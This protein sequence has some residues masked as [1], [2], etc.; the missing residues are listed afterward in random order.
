MRSFLFSLRSILVLL[1][2]LAAL[3]AIGLA[4]YNASRETVEARRRA[5]EQVLSLVH[6]AAS[7]HKTL[8]ASA[9]QLL[10]TLVELPE[11][12]PGQVEACNALLARLLPLHPVFANLGVTDAN[13]NV[14][15]SAVPTTTAVNVADRAWFIRA[16]Q[17]RAFASGD[18]QIGR[19]TGKAVI[20]FSHPILDADNQV[21][22]VAFAALDLSW[23][24]KLAQAATLPPEAVYTVVD[25]QGRILARQPGGEAWLG[26]VA[27]EQSVV[28][29]ALATSKEGMA[30]APGVDGVMRLY[31]Y[32]P[33]L[34]DGTPGAYVLVGLPVS[35]VYA[36][37]G[38]MLWINLG[39]LGG[40]AVLGLLAA[41][42]GGEVF[43][44]RPIHSLL[45]A[46]RRM[47]Q[48][49]LSARTAIPPG[50][51][52]LS[53]LARAFD[54]M[55]ESLESAQRNYRLLFENLPQG[56]AVHEMIWDEEGNAVDYRFLS[57][58]PAFERLT[59]LK[60][61]DILGKT[62]RQVL[63]EI[64]AAW[65]GTH[66]QVVR[67][68]QPIVYE[69]FASPLG[70]YYS[71]LAYKPAEGQFATIVSDITE[72]TRHE[73]EV[74]AQAQIAYALAESLELQFLLDRLLLAAIHAVPAAEKGF[75]LL[76]DERGELQLRS[77]KGYADRR[78]RDVRFPSELGYI[79]LAFHQRRGLIIA[80]A[81]AEPKVR[82]Q[83]EI[84]ELM[85][86]LSAMAVPL[87]VHE[88]TIGVIA[89]Q[90]STRKAA[91]DEHDLNVL[92]TMASTAALII[93]NAR[94]YEE[95]ANRLERIEALRKIDM[96]ITS[97]LDPRVSLSVLLDQVTGRLSVDA[98][99]VLLYNPYL[100]ELN[101]A[102]AR[103]FRTRTIERTRLRL[104]EGIA[105][106]VALERSLV[107]IQ[108]LRQEAEFVRKDLL[109]A[110]GFISYIAVPMI[111]KG[112]LLGVLEVFNRSP[113]N[114]S[115]EW[116]AF[117]EA[118]AAQAAIAIE[119]AQ[120]FNGLQRSN[121]ELMRAY[122]TTIEGWS[123]ALDL[124]DKET[125]GHTQRVTQMTLNLGGAMGMSDAELVHVRR[126]ALLHDIGKMGIP[127]VILLKPGPLTEEEWE[128]MRKHPVYAYEMLYP[129]E[130]LRPALDI[131]YCHHEK[132]D[133]TGYP[134]GLKGEQIP[135]AARIFA[136]VDVW[137]AL[138]S[139]RP[140]RPA[141]SRQAALEYIREQNGKHFDPEVVRVFM[142]IIASE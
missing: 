52:E 18:Y 131:P 86:V 51:D 138:T 139:D 113:L 102:A 28:S 42:L 47:A 140:Y 99:A 41:W 61:D 13:G 69:Q 141:W 66:G 2:L 85:R 101:Y 129:I 75:I 29:Q 125:E 16:V 120:L 87:I 27:S 63:P 65:V 34:V 81:Q 20:V 111:A 97:S 23:L 55:A 59:G 115:Q 117:L 98:A 92:S 48:G 40:A 124:R 74:E 95:T 88:R 8:I 62:V 10:T 94:L 77:L 4:V 44:L 60:A 119:N 137:D 127:D 123:R 38:R 7:E 3:P 9:R 78:I 116:L 73:R 58:N 89:L 126:G 15:C 49:D 142:K 136:V 56:F 22:A 19:I 24:D 108:D 121:L 128:I 30:E 96:A 43:L 104:G 107:S 118:L 68:G 37:S 79:A 80:D 17:S 103:G 14:Y 11:L 90:N 105:G 32:T 122:D 45:R 106:R 35:Q 109:A 114:I 72:R 5:Q 135:L 46:T 110:E 33:L 133:G 84:E 93:E 50:R 67:S 39:I 6:V 134:R 112:Q 36:E 71:V 1:V 26:K 76:A 21:V 64:E 130:Y 100:Q 54:S 12:W 83:G 70:K 57:V 132:W 91:F 53:Q 25:R 31:A 82:Y